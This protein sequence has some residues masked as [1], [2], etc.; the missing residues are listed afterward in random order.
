MRF[1]LLALAVVT[2]GGCR[3]Q[4]MPPP[5]LAPAP[6]D[7][8]SRDESVPKLV[9][10]A[11]YDQASSDMDVCDKQHPTGYCPP[12]FTCCAFDCWGGGGPPNGWCFQGAGCP[13]C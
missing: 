8:A 2:L 10:L 13:V 5:D 6:I 7:L 3:S 4:L 9:D 11:S 1:L 12:G